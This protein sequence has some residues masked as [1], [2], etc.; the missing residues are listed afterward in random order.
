[1][2]KASAI[3]YDVFLDSIELI[4]LFSLHFP[5]L[6]IFHFLLGFRYLIFPRKLIENE[7][8]LSTI[9]FINGGSESILE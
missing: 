5:Y 7:S 1:M 6:H 2:N 4:K 9:R 3:I 8:K